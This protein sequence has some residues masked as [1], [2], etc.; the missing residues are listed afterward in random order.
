MANNTTVLDIGIPSSGAVKAVTTASKGLEKVLSSISQ[1]VQEAFSVRG[2]QDYLQTVKR[3]GKDLADEL[4]VLQMSFGK[5]KVAIAQAVAPIAAVFIPWLNQAIQAVIRFAGT[6][7]QFFGGLMAGV[8]GNDALGSSAQ[9]AADA[10][11]RLK[12]AATAAGKA[13]KRSLMGFDELERLNAPTGSGG[14]GGSITVGSLYDTVSPEVQAVVDK[15]L[16]LLAPLMAIDLT[17]LKTALQGLWTTMSGLASVVGK[18]LEWLWYELLTPF[19]AWILEVLAP[20]LTDAWAAK[21]ELVTAALEPLMAGVQSLWETLQ[22]VVAYIGETVVASIQSWQKAFESLTEVFRVKGSQVTA[23]FQNI[24][25]VVT[26]VWNGIQPVLTAMQT[27]TTAVFTAMGGYVQMVVGSIL[28][29]LAGLTGYLAGIFTGDWEQA[30]E[31]IQ[32]FL[33]G[34]VNSIIGLLNAMINRLV[35][36]LNA[37]IKAAN[38]LSFTVPSWVPGIGGSKFGFNMKTVSAPQIPYLAKG[39]VLPANKPFLAMVGDQ[40]HGTN[41]EAPLSTIQEAVAVVMEDYITAMMEGFASMVAE[42]RQTRQ[43]I[44]GIQVGD[45]VIGQAAER[46]RSRMAMM[47]GRRM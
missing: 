30:W 34:I 21:L 29:A 3:F 46:Y 9:K 18:S 4:L 35:T 44:A 32:N 26:A 14:A 38:K 12:I 27:H 8:T 47:S 11:E 37:V 6:V 25:Q 7:G 2:Y 40:R 13:A 36:A 23:I 1:G 39:A 5:M 41:V 15:I 28:D 24:G 45:S 10:E 20:A 22:P 42:Q 17:P 19:I 31:G 16:A 43:A 33:K